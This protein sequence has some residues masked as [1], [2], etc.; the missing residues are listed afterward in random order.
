[1]RPHPLK[2]DTALQA[3]QAALIGP[4]SDGFVDHLLAPEIESFRVAARQGRQFVEIEAAVG[5]LF[6]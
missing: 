3:A 5:L 6:I 4:V 1:M 2:I